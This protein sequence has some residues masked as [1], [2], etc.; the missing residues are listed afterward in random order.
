MLEL[1]GGCSYFSVSEGSQ[2][3]KQVTQGA[4][5]APSAVWRDQPKRRSSSRQE[6][7]ASVGSVGRYPDKLRT[8]RRSNAKT[9]EFLTKLESENAELRH[10]AVELA[11][12]IQKLVESQFR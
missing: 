4:S 10:Q 9:A 5:T 12:Q 1:S 3:Q 2:V 11:L 7:K 8:P 6:N